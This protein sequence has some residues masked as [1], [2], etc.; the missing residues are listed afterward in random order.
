MVRRPLRSHFSVEDQNRLIAVLGES[1]TA[2]IR[3]AA[4]LRPF[5]DPYLKCQAVMQ[6]IDALAGDLTGDPRLFHVKPH[7]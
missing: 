7:G 2:V 5:S 3:C 1:R 6:T 4:S